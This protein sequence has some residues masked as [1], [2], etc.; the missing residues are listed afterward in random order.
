MKTITL[1]VAFRDLL[2]RRDTVE[3]YVDNGPLDIIL[4]GGCPI[5]HL[6]CISKSI[7]KSWKSMNLIVFQ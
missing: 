2:K 6:R 5:S 1:P 3:L 4:V 7:G